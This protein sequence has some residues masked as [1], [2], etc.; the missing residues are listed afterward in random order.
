MRRKTS[1]VILTYNQWELT[2]MC[3]E[4]LFTHTNPEEMEVIIIDNGSTD[5]T[6]AHLTKETRIIFVANESNQGFAKACNQ[7]AELATGNEILFLNN[8]TIVTNEWLTRMRKTLD[9]DQKIGLV[10]PMSNYVSGEQLIQDPYHSLEEIEAYAEKRHKG[11]HEK[12]AYVMRLVGFCLLVRKKVLEDIGGFDERFEIGSF[13]DDDFCLRAVQSGYRLAIALDVHIH[14]HGHATFT[15]SPEINFNQTYL[16]NYQRY[17]QKWGED[18]S[19]FMHGRP[20][21]VQLVPQDAK[22]I[23]DIGC[24]AGATGLQLINRQNSELVGVEG[25]EKMAQIA[26]SYYKAVYAINLDETVPPLKQESFDVILF[27][28]ILEHL[29][30]PWKIVQQYASFLKKGGAIIA[31]IPNI[32]HAEALLPL[33]SGRFDYR[34]AGI[35]DKTHLRF[36]TPQTLYTLF[37]TDQF[38]IRQQFSTHVPIDAKV[39]TF[40]NEVSLLGK[41]FDLDLEGLSD[42]IRTY[43]SVVLFKKL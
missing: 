35:L 40:F 22:Q 39:S 38:S 8:D 17:V 21:L 25:N 32:G 13:E 5:E 12:K 19:Y 16:D 26:R 34:D 24:G 33:L 3:L 23:L 14:H 7:G 11:F 4:S 20:E 1:I 6:V 9:S 2:K 15:G 27:A 31:S 18:L 30:D 10:G 29:K 28:D 41:K 42:A 43:Q 36:F 37:P